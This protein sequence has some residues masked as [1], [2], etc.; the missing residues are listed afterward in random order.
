MN[1]GTVPP[2]P[3]GGDLKTWAGRLTEYLI[4]SIN[5]PTPAAPVRLAH[6]TGTEKALEDG[7]MLFD[8][9]VGLPVVSSGGQW[10]DCAGNVVP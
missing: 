6:R 5:A 8:P 10:V 2:S 7:I 9:T 1:F 4:R 3:H